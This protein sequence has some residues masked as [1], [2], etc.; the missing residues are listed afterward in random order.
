M[1]MKKINTE[2]A[3]G[4]ANVGSPTASEIANGHVIHTTAN[5]S[6]ENFVLNRAD[7]TINEALDFAQGFSQH[8]P[9]DDDLDWARL[10]GEMQYDGVNSTVYPDSELCQVEIPS[11]GWYD[12]CVGRI[13]A[14]NRGCVF[15]MK[16]AADKVYR[17]NTWDIGGATIDELDLDLTNAESNGLRGIACDGSYL[18][19]CYANS[20]TGNYHLIKLDLTTWT[21]LPVEER[22][23]GW[24]YAS[25][26]SSV[27]LA[28]ARMTKVAAFYQASATVSF[29]LWETDDTSW[30]TGVGNSGGLTVIA[31]SYHRIQATYNQIYAVVTTNETTYYGK[32]LI[33]ADIADLS[34]GTWPAAPIEIDDPTTDAMVGFKFLKDSF[35]TLTNV[36]VLSY[37]YHSGGGTWTEVSKG[38]VS[39]LDLDKD[40]GAGDQPQAV[41]DGSGR[42]W[43]GYHVPA[44]AAVGSDGGLVL[45]AFD[46]A[47]FSPSLPDRTAEPRAVI[48]IADGEVNAGDNL[49]VHFDGRS[50]VVLNDAGTTRYA[51][52]LHDPGAR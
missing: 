44:S 2:W 18:Y 17:I 37:Y 4:S 48:A 19:V 32:H 50:L 40:T 20:V 26:A 14:T 25:G 28:M 3:S 49:H 47:L 22:D 8:P 5:S 11:G 34:D 15:Y 6:W 52:L 36:G 31:S 13:P 42:L 24:S 9:T 46:A 23:T 16:L 38:N 12:S 43:L 41:V 51:R 10:C 39:A 21:G 27:K 7:S 35:V 1:S 29:G 45:V 33:C 30:Q